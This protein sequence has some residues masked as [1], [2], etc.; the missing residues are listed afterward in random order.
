MGLLQLLT[1]GVVTRLLIGCTYAYVGMG[2]LDLRVKQ[3]VIHQ[4][5]SNFAMDQ[6]CGED[7]EEVRVGGDHQRYVLYIAFHPQSPRN[8]PPIPRIPSNPSPTE[9]PMPSATVRPSTRGVGRTESPSHIIGS[10]PNSLA[11]KSNRV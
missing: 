7:G 8:R 10:P 9:S 5:K 4:W 3:V 6:P 11:I 1:A 2:R